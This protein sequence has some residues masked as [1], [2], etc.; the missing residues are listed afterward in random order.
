[1]PHFH[2]CPA[3][4]VSRTISRSRYFVRAT[5]TTTCISTNETG[6][7]W[8][9]ILH[10]VL[11]LRRALAIGLLEELQCGASEARKGVTGMYGYLWTKSDFSLPVQKDRSYFKMFVQWELFWRLRAGVGVHWYLGLGQGW[12]T[13]ERKGFFDQYHIS[14]SNSSHN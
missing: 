10:L 6:I 7:L 13:G 3:A 9:F 2:N 8:I 1:M 14:I 5:T 12:R 4:G 11:L